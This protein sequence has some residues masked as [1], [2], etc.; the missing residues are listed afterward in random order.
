VMNVNHE[1]RISRL[2]TPPPRGG[3]KGGGEGEGGT[4]G[5]IV[6]KKIPRATHLKCKEN[7]IQT[8]TLA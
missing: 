6:E 5:E 7:G 3:T 1:R 8:G 2:T 4:A